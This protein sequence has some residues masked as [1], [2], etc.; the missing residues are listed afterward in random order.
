MRRERLT[1]DTESG[2]E[3]DVEDT[4]EMDEEAESS[5]ERG[6]VIQQKLGGW[7]N[8]FPQTSLALAMHLNPRAQA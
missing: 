1:R 6:G 5:L 2:V 4:D 8:S 3:G 7:Q